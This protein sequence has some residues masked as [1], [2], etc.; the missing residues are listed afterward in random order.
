MKFSCV[1]TKSDYIATK[2]NN[3]DK[4]LRGDKIKWGLL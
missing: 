4:A 2:M 3:I 1:C